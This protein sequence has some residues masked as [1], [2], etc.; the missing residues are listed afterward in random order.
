MFDRVCSTAPKIASLPLTAEPSIGRVMIPHRPE[1]PPRNYFTN[2]LNAVPNT[3]YGTYNRSP[4]TSQRVPYGGGY[5]MY[6]YGSTP[7][8][9]SYNSAGYG[10]GYG[11][12][13]NGVIS[14]PESRYEVLPMT[15]Y[16][17]DTYL[18][19]IIFRFIRA[20]EEST[21]PTFQA[22]ESLT[23]AINS[24]AFMME[25]TFGSLNMSFQAVLSVI[26]NF[27]QARTF[28][29]QFFTSILT[30]RI[31]HKFFSILV[32]ILSK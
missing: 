27:S 31:F 13:Y 16:F 10:G 20:A 19:Q 11:M 30:L 24:I 1:I 22:I 17:S 28:L 23:R 9:A 29:K 25:S 4:Y 32:G 5:S 6:G 14:N 12:N 21:R 15:S 26:E 3:A 7:Y 8:Y 2:N 18:R